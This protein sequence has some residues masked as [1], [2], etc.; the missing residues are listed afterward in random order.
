[1]TILDLREQLSKKLVLLENI[2]KK[3]DFQLPNTNHLTNIVNKTTFDIVVI[4]EF[5]SGKSTLINAMLGLDILPTLL[6]PTTAR[7]TYISYS[8]KP[9][10]ILKMKDGKT[11]NNNFDEG[12]LKSLIADNVKDVENIE[13]IE[14]YINNQILREG[15]RLIDTPGTNDT[16]EQRVAITYGL[17]PEADAVIYLTIHPVTASNVMVFKEYILNNKI[18]NIFF[19]LNKIDLLGEQN[20]LAVKDA[21]RWFQNAYNEPIKHFYALSALEYLEGFID[22]NDNLIKK[23]NFKSF[24]NSFIQF[25]QCTEK[26]KNLELQYSALFESVKYQVIQLIKLK[27]A[28]LSISED[29]FNEKKNSLKQDLTNFREQVKVLEHQFDKEFDDLIFKIESSLNNLLNEILSTSDDIFSNTKGEID[30]ILKNIEFHIKN[31]YENWRE[32]NEPI[33]NEFI[34]SLVEETSIHLASSF[35]KMNTSIVKFSDIQLFKKVQDT[36]ASGIAEILRDDLKT[37]FAS[38]A[39]VVGGMFLLSTA[40]IFPPFAF[41]LNPLVS[42]YRKKWIE[43]QKMQMKP[44]LISSIQESFQTFRKQILQ[45]INSHRNNLNNQITRGLADQEIR[46]KTELTNIDKERLEEKSEIERRIKSYE[47]TIIKIKEL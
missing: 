3:I 28:G 47:E 46:I 23:S 30:L 9:Q 24:Y 34:N 4:G 10:I 16:D 2:L 42:I 7:I 39:A 12:F 18:K 22:Q 26:Y 31:K 17:I 44:Q 6:Q 25:L 43:S 15:I 21:R 20:E 11:I 13:C 40:G 19:V 38:T 14:V 45:N 8:D 35:D 29:D 33:I 1:M 37:Q 5:T 27:I 36:S 32:R 41:L